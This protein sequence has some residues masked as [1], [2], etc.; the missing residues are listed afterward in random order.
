[1]ATITAQE[2]NTLSKKLVGTQRSEKLGHGNGSMILRVGSDTTI[3]VTYRYQNAADKTRKMGLGSLNAIGGL[4]VARAKCHELVKLRASLADRDPIAQVER[5]NAEAKA[6]K[7]VAEVARESRKEFTL[8]KLVDAYAKHLRSQGKHEA[9][10]DVECVN[11]LHLVHACPNL[12]AT[13]A[14]QLKPRD[15]K[16]PMQK[17]ILAGKRRQ[18]AR[19]RATIATAYKKAIEAESDGEL[20]G[21]NGFGI[22]SNPAALVKVPKGAFLAGDRTLSDIELREYML[23]VAELPNAQI[24]AILALSLRLGG[25]RFE[26]LLRLVRSDVDIEA[27]TV[28]LRDGKGNR[29]KPRL[30]LLPC[31]PQAWELVAR[32]LLSAD[33]ETGRLFGHRG[34]D[35]TFRRIW[36][37]SLSGAAHRISLQLQAESLSLSPWR[38]GDVR[39]T[40]ETRLARMGVSMELRAQ[41]LSHGLGGVQAK[42]YDRNDYLDQKLAAL[43][44][45]TKC[46]PGLTFTKS[47]Q[48]GPQSPQGNPRK[49]RSS[50]NRL[51]L[52]TNGKSDENCARYLGGVTHARLRFGLARNCHY[53]DSAI[54][55]KAHARR[56][57]RVQRMGHALAARSHARLNR[58]GDRPCAR[59]GYAHA[60]RQGVRAENRLRS[61]YNLF[62][63]PCVHGPAYR[64]ADRRR[65]RLGGRKIPYCHLYRASRG[66]AK[67]ARAAYRIRRD[68]AI[69]QARIERRLAMM[70]D[71]QWHPNILSLRCRY[72]HPSAWTCRRLAACVSGPLN[73]AMSIPAFFL[74]SR[75][76]SVECRRK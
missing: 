31:A 33:R 55:A 4:A 48:S 52:P 19:L 5:D 75:S 72:R 65:C 23:R 60:D 53:G 10:D 11:R 40:C 66:K 67:A 59:E 8:T 21:F 37:E 45:S 30:H 20:V 2:V 12:A 22:E 16:E 54:G 28:T 9:A 73:R 3:S 29:P 26:Q 32:L 51:A 41:I 56:R 18:A 1:M 71:G 34:A 58:V 14:K 15:F 69:P 24:R 50:A 6:A 64:R 27:R 25:Q 46:R 62:H 35:G 43:T 38:L 68:N 39:R 47:S 63:E 76:D 13:P 36:A 7:Q 49:S 70:L 42:H 17:L 57:D 61:R 44:C 74:G